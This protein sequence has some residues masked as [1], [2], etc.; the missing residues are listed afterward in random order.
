MKK[1]WPI[2][3]CRFVLLFFLGLMISSQWGQ[4][5]ELVR[6]DV[7]HEKGRYR[8]RSEILVA[9]TPDQV[10]A[11]ITDVENLHTLSSDILESRLLERKSPNR[12]IIRTELRSCIVVFCLERTLLEKVILK[13]QEVVYMIQP[14]KNSFRYGWVR[15]K[16][17]NAQ[18]GTRVVYSSELVPDFWV[19]P[20]IG[21]FL[22]KGKFYDNTVEVMERLEKRFEK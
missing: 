9:L 20:M 17:F 6:L 8:I 5:A 3:G 1:K 12:L 22:L 2:P 15:W 19:P 21:P 11:G 13:K 4:T 16:I 14:A 10:W 7:A 18:Q